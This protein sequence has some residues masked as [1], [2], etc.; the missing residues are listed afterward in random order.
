MPASSSNQNNINKAVWN[1]CDT[2]GGVIS[3]DTYKDF[4]LAVLFLTILAQKSPTSI[5]SGM[6]A[7]LFTH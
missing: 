1:A 5:G 2:F 7:L 6:N 3:A 4:I